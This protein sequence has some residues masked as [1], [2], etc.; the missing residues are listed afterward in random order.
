MALRYGCRSS[1]QHGIRHV[2]WH[3]SARFRYGRIQSRSSVTGTLEIYNHKYQ[4]DHITNVTPS[5]LSKIPRRIHLNA[6][7]PINILKSRIE[8][9][10]KDYT[11]MDSMNPVTTPRKNFDDLLF[12]Q[13]HPS[14]LPGDTYYINRE[15]IL[16]THTSTH[17]LEVLQSKRNDRYLLTADVYRR[18]EINVSHYPV[19]HQM[20]G[21]RI[22]DRGSLD[23]IKA[24]MPS[25]VSEGGGNIA[26]IVHD[27][28][29]HSAA[30]PIQPLHTQ[31]ET[32]LVATHLKKSLESL[33]IELFRYE[34]AANGN[35][36]LQVRW[37]E[38]YFPFTSP[39][40][41][42]EVLYQG[43]WLEVFGCGVTQQQIID[44]S[45]NP[46]KIGWAFGLGLERIGMPLFNIP[47][48]RLFWS[49]DPRIT[50]Q[51]KHPISS[52]EPFPKFQSFSKYPACYKDVSFWL[53]EGTDVPCNEV[54][55]IVR[56]SG[57]DL[58]EDVTLIDQFQHPKTRRHSQCFRINYRSLDRTLTNEEC[59]AIHEI[60]RS[61]LVDQYSVDLR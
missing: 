12:P 45:G 15:H 21:I 27:T 33:F 51:F 61:K 39:S 44:N 23:D 29:L 53:R 28:P 54:M 25:G 18:D 57:G 11:V 10:F 20:E 38:A 52:T 59:D 58:I 24:G 55:E 19:F 49:T 9:H 40:W 42:M 1:C 5:L 22:F 34:V 7:N 8:S 17:Q 50:D 4:T 31:H 16:R 3:H 41:E 56:D 46:D 32:E 37:V 13:D 43:K 36:P 14:R 47:D 48:I 26:L 35:E 6:H 60:V 30:N 2:V